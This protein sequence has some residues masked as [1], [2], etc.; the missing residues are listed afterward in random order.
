M[1]RESNPSQSCQLFAQYEA[2]TDKLTIRLKKV[3]YPHG[4]HTQYKHNI[5]HEYLIYYQN[6]AFNRVLEMIKLPV[7]ITPRFIPCIFLFS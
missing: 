5:K 2:L 4:R 6:N 3:H 7:Q 1:V